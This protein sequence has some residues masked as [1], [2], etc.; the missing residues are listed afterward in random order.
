MTHPPPNMRVA[1]ATAYGSPSVIELTSTAAP[2]LGPEDVLIRTHATTVSSGDW[3]IRSLEIPRGMKTLY[4]LAMGVRR[5]RQSVLGT[6]LSGKVVAL[7]DRVEGYR[8]GDRVVAFP[9]ESMGAHAELVRMP[10][11]GDGARIIPLPERF[12]FVEGAAMCFGGVTATHYL[13]DLAR[14]GEGTRVAILGA[15]GAVGSAGVQIA[16]ALGAD[17]TAV[18]RGDARAALLEAGAARHIDYQEASWL[19]A[20]VAYDVVF[21]TVGATNYRECR[22]A[23]A[24]GGV[25]L[26]AVAGL[27]GLLAAPFQGRLRGHRVVAGV[28][29]E[30]V[31]Q[32]RFLADLA[33]RGLYTPW[34]DS[35]FGFDRIVDAHERVDRGH[36]RGSVVVRFP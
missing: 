7:G 25:L 26:R 4:R 8:V 29:T 9:G 36:K 23:L 19:D 13:R 24:P 6:E 11:R 28:S 14:I 10:T 3:R 32:M 35:E 30:K 34:I 16:R 5:P 33:E 2:S 31:E 1:V 15:S 17:V 21:D 27:G 18:S 20:G 12:S 22:S